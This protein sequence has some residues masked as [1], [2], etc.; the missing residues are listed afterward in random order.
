MRRAAVIGWLVLLSSCYGAQS[1]MVANALLGTAVGIASSGI[2][3]AS[4]GCY[5]SCP[6][7]TTCNPDTGYCDELPCRGQCGPG[8]TCQLNG[9]FSQCVRSVPVELRLN[10]REL[11]APL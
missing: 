2:S 4:G 1:G 5:A 6:V 10:D 3:R 8:E 9:P 11:E 7:G